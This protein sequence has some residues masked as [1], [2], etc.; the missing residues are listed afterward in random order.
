MFDLDRLD[1]VGH[2]DPLAALVYCGAS[3]Y[4]KATIV[5]GELLTIDEPD[6]VAQA[7]DWANRLVD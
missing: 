5:N 6:L 4:T 1:R 7:K 3:H 2:P